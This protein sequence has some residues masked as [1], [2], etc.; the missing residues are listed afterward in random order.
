MIASHRVVFAAPGQVVLE[1]EE[2][3]APGRGQVLLRTEATLISTGTELTALTGDFPPNS[4]WSDYIRFPTGIGY[5]SVACVSQVGAEVETVAMGDRVASTA[6]HASH[7]VRSA[8]HLYRLPD[9]VSSEVAAFATLA[10]IVMGGLRRGRLAFGESVVVVGAGLLGQLAVLFARAAGAWPV[11][12]LD[13]AE[14]R[15]ETALRM[16]ATAVL[17]LASGDAVA[18]V[19]RLTAGR[20]A[21]VVFEITGNPVAMAGAVRLAR[22][23]GRVVLLGSPRGPVTIDLHD[24]VHTLGLEVIGAHNSAHPPVGT[25]HAPWTIARHVELFLAWQAAGEIDVSP[26]ITHRFPWQQAPEAYRMLVE[27]RSQ[28][29]GVV[30]D[31]R[32]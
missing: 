25:P 22:R 28:A 18:D 11:I 31:W 32:D 13:P 9:G 1:P 27:D 19:G 10:E 24:E 6:P 2:L 16:G 26:L 23:L 4:R 21:D 29:L 12:V 20:L 8:E 30:L 3:P 15:L 7:A 5:S 17:P 14:R